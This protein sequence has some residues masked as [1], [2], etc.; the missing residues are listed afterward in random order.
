[1]E[2]N[3]GL[4]MLFSK[5]TWNDSFGQDSCSPNLFEMIVGLFDS[6]GPVVGKVG[7]HLRGALKFTQPTLSCAQSPEILRPSLPYVMHSTCS[8]QSTP[9]YSVLSSQITT[10]IWTW[11]SGQFEQTTLDEPCPYRHPP[12]GGLIGPN[13]PNAQNPAVM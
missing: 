7:D 12:P 6:F 13:T 2:G 9:F 4:C 1:M 11:L 3:D 5:Y 8:K 10:H